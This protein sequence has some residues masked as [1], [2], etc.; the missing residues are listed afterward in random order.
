MMDGIG[1]IDRLLIYKTQMS[2]W[3]NRLME[4]HMHIRMYEERHCIGR[5]IYT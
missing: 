5:T 3:L 2:R 1:M 4:I